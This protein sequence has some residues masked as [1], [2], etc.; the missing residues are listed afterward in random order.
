M[1]LDNEN[2]E[3]LNCSLIVLIDSPLS[4]KLSI[5]ATFS[6]VQIEHLPGIGTSRETGINKPFDFAQTNAELAAIASAPAFQGSVFL[7]FSEQTVGRISEHPD[8]LAERHQGVDFEKSLL[9]ADALV[10]EEQ[11]R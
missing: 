11:R 8:H 2:L 3:T 1:C 4:A 7:P 10:R 6:W 9:F 5:W